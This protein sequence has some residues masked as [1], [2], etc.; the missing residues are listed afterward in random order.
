MLLTFESWAHVLTR[1]A[2]ILEKVGKDGGCWGE[3]EQGREDEKV[4]TR[5]T[6]NGK[7]RARGG[8]RAGQTFETCEAHAHTHTHTTQ[9]LMHSKILLKH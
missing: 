5:V 7:E 6:S 4:V 2:D 8:A 9:A 1:S 3:G